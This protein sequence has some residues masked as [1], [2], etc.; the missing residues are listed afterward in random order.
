MHVAFSVFAFQ[1]LTLK[2]E[3]G[4]QE[5]IPIGGMERLQSVPGQQPV[6]FD[7]LESTLVANFL[8]MIAVQ[9]FKG[10]F[11]GK[12]DSTR[13]E[14]A[15]NFSQSLLGVH[16]RMAKN[17]R[18]GHQIEGFVGIRHPMRIALHDPLQPTMATLSHRDRMR[19]KTM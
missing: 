4:K 14:H 5:E 11:V 3:H 1:A 16:I 13:L 6:E 18:Q 7:P 19:F 12:Q 8:V 10:R 15:T 17:I 9:P 2:D